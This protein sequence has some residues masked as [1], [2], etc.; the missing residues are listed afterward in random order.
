MVE[1]PMKK[2][3]PAKAPIDTAIQ[4]HIGQQLRAMYDETASEPVPD[5]LLKLLDALSVDGKSTEDRGSP[6]GSRSDLS[7]E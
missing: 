5:N 2:N 3:R 4:S 1:D 7:G 6:S